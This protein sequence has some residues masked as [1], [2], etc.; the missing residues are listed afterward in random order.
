MIDY[1][2][3][4][5]RVAGV[6]V[7]LS[8]VIV[9]AIFAGAQQ[10]PDLTQLSP[11]QLAKIEVTSVS[12]K[13]QKLKDTA[14]AVYVITQQDI[15]NSTATS[16]PEL[17]RM[18]P[19]L[20]V[21]QVNGNTWAISARGFNHQFA[22]KML[23]LI[24]GRSVFHPLFSGVTWSQQDLML[25][26]VERIEVIR[27]PGATVWGTNAVNGVINIITKSAQDTSGALITGGAGDLE[28]S[29]G[30]ARYGGKLGHST[31]YRIYSKYYDD[32]PTEDPLGQSGGDSQRSIRTGFRTDSRI[33][34][35]DSLMLEG[36]VYDNKVGAINERFSYTAPF[37]SLV[38]D[39]QTQ[40]GTNVLARW[41]HK[42][43]TGSETDFQASYSHIT[44][45]SGSLDVN[46]DVVS[47]SVQQAMPIGDRHNIVAGVQFDYRDGRT[48][49]SSPVDSWDPVNP[50]FEIASGFIQDEM[51]FAS[52]AVRF[53]AGIRI[54]HN[55]LNGTGAQP[56]ARL[57]WKINPEHS[58]WLAYSLA[59]RSLSPADTA[60]RVNIS[61]IPGATVPQVVR[62]FGNADMEPEKVNAFELGYR[63]QP[64]KILS[65]DLAA[66]YNRYSGLL[67]TEAGQPFFEAGPPPRLV[68]PVVEHNDVSGVSFGG[69]FTTHW[70][71]SDRI[72]LAGAYSFIEFSMVQSAKTVGDAAAQLNG[73]TPRH[74]LSQDTSINLTRTVRWDA[75]FS[76]VDRRT[77]QK[78]PGY[79]QV[80]T[81]IAWQARQPVELSIG[82]KNL[83]NKEHLEIF[84][85]QPGRISTMIGRSVYGKLA[86]RF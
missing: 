73:G 19:G 48:S 55:T 34:E 33:S 54:D 69:E 26:D 50:S 32:G 6:S 67:G 83:F 56:N 27:G 72:H 49:S 23:V 51:L 22:D 78:V 60:V 44:E 11:E 80:D 37:I 29:F 40:S 45:P 85:E 58:V 24:D 13:E 3:L 17:L 20:D 70:A 31:A 77:Y 74:K 46:G 25:E 64:Q 16:I 8:C 71:L 82:A 39:S 86:W 18:V 79:T 63:I 81:K 41:N 9:F 4:G 36:D 10:E 43:L 52:G 2:K 1:S 5:R 14:A 28:R 30:S 84:S 66:F 57:L 35:R 65:F 21:A 47:L 15:R 12:K 7:R 76:F 62:F 68:L 75:A 38:A 53:T 61:A 59:N 42:S